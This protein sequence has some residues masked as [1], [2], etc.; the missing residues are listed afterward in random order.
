MENCGLNGLRDG[1][2]VEFLNSMEYLVDIV[3]LHHH[4]RL[5]SEGEFWLA[6]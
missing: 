1:L 4:E 3:S 2:V 6:S 5:T